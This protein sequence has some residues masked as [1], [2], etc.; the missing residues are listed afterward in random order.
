MGSAADSYESYWM[1]TAPGPEYPRLT[2]SLEVDAVVVG[3]GV[4]GLCTAGELARAGCR[5]ALVE[6]DRIA[7]GVTG[8]TTAKLSALHGL[9]YARLAREQGTDRARWYAQSQQEA[10]EHV[11]RTAAELGVDCQL[12]RVPGYVYTETEDALE[13]VR[14]EA[15]A[16]ADAG[17]A[18]VFTEETGLPFRVAGAVRVADQA[19]FHPRRYL[20]A[21]AEDLVARGGLVFEHTRATGLTEGRP[22]RVTTEGGAVV[23]AAEVVVATHYPVFDRAL[24]FARLRPVRELVVAGAVPEDA[25][26]QGMYVTPEH[27][28]RS[29]RTAPYGDGRRLLI[30]TGEKFTPGSSGVRRR[31]DRLADWACE[32]FPSLRP[33]YRWAAQDNSTTDGVPYVGRFHVGTQHVHVAA[34][35]DGWGM[36]GGVMAGRLLAGVIIGD[37]PRWAPLYDPRRLRPLREAPALV[38]FQA[39]V[40]RHLVGDWIG[41]PSMP[42]DQDLGAGEGAVVRFHG[43]RVAV[44]RDREG[45][46]HTVGARCTHLGCTVHFNE[47]EQSWDCPCH[48]SRFALDGTVVQGPATRPLEPLDTDPPG[49]APGRQDD[50]R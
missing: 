13:D 34:G 27:R 15:R 6:A 44:C 30:V 8:H 21:L 7:S 35:F 45:R 26:P 42:D 29:V 20:L 48:G 33:G 41:V 9:R 1:A 3:G 18:A 46:L 19:Q 39:E 28:T 43:R 2:E 24:L 47:A 37:E 22:C 40:A 16:A 14:A 32:R 11:V 31:H 4:A 36:S 12:E 17:L 25:D 10:V 38:K 5:V 23:S 50:A 49:P